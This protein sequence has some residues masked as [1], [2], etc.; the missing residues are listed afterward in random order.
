MRIIIAKIGNDATVSFA[1]KELCR[2]I[3]EMD[4]TVVLDVR[5]YDAYNETLKNII[6]VGEGFVEKSETDTV[7]I[8]VKDSAGFISGSNARSVLIAVYRFM[9]ELGC[10]Y[11]YPG[12]D[13]E[14][15]PSKKLSYSDLT[16]EVK[17]TASYNHRGIC[18]EGTV[19]YEHVRNMID[20]IPKV[21]MNEYFFQFFTP[22][23]FFKQYY[24]EFEDGIDDSGVDAIV[25]ALND[26]IAK[27]SLNY[28]AVG[29]G[30]TC[31][32]FGLGASGWD[33]YEGEPPKEI[34]DI[35]ALVNGE[36][37]FT[38]DIPLN[39]NLCY[40]NPTVREKIVDYV[41]EYCKNNLNKNYIAFWMADGGNNHCEC[42]NCIKKTP[43]DFLIDM[44]NAIDEKL[45]ALDI[46][47]K[48]IFPVYNDLMWA[49][50][51]EKFNNPDRFVC[52]FAPI[53]RSYSVSYADYDFSGEIKLEPYKRNQN[54]FHYSLPEAVEMAEKWRREQNCTNSILF[55][56]H[57]MWDHHYDPG[58]YAVAKTLQK[59]MTC[60]EKIGVDGMVSCQLQRVAFPNNLPMYCMAKTLWNK[61]ETFEGI[62]KEYFEEV[63]GEKAKDVEEYLS[64]LSELFELEVLRGEKPY[65]KDVLIAKF[66]KAKP[67]V[68]DFNNSVVSKMAETSKEWKHLSYHVP[69][70]KMYADMYI[71]RFKGDEDEC[72]AVFNKFSDYVRSISDDTNLEL[73]NEFYGGTIYNNL[74]GWRKTI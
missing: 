59:D 34:K 4:K 28:Y 2:L 5:K 15:I 8:S 65:D 72:W 40:S 41:V 29:H 11:L 66:E 64:A 1:A 33:K 42:E 23:T 30:W 43:A 61:N 6:W 62:V 21:G 58:Y 57:L 16:V 17:D 10:R 46:N 45:T 36:R 47:T 56:Y 60:L 68:D 27:R 9:Y 50:E 53:S 20:W 73:D 71:A 67:F 74:F 18:I 70:V 22:A 13:G 31:A 54:E 44:L 24:R 19:G 35:L 37:K 38:G 55:D 69:M 12:K 7:A 48:L 14:K 49:P 32:P 3:K 63:Y 25:S 26:E 52:M 39:T 51:V